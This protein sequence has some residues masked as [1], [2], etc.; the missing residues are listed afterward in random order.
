MTVDDR[1]FSTLTRDGVTLVSF[2]AP[3]CGPCRTLAPIFE[4]CA[5]EKSHRA[6]FGSCNIDASPAT[7]VALRIVT[8]PTIVFFAG[9]GREVTRIDGVMPREDLDFVV[10]RVLAAIP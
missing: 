7:S 2:W 5:A 4:A 9:D 10:E 1:T 6:R 3:W 8:V